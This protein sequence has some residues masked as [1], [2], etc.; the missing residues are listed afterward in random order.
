VQEV[1]E[2]LAAKWVVPQIVNDAATVG[3]RARVVELRVGDP[4]KLRAQQRLDLRIPRRVDRGFVRQH[5]IGAGTLR[6]RQRDDD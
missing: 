4:W 6:H 5:G 2:E 1:A 3:I